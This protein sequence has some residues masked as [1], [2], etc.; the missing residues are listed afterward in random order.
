MSINACALASAPDGS[1]TADQK[2]GFSTSGLY[3]DGS[4]CQGPS[5]CESAV[6]TSIGASSCNGNFSCTAIIAE[7]VNDGSCNGNVACSCDASTGCI[8]A[9]QIDRTIGIGSCN[10][11]SACFSSTGSIGDGSC[12]GQEGSCF[13]SS[14]TVG[15]G[16]CL[17]LF[18]CGNLNQDSQFI[19]EGS[20]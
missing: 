1:A 2:I 15:S 18:S 20:W 10:G 16:S 13:Q 4:S 19:E 12:V 5:A 7:F 6:V 8:D 14:A 17:G 9:V 11:T 3:Q